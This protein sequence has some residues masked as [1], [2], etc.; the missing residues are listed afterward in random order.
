MPFNISPEDITT[1]YR[2][3]KAD[4]FYDYGNLNLLKFA[5]FE[6]DLVENLHALRNKLLNW[7]FEDYDE[8]VGSFTL[9]MKECVEDIKDKPFV[10]FSDVQR[11]WEHASNIKVDFRIIGQHPVEFHIL[12]SLWID[13][14][15][16]AFLTSNVYKRACAILASCCNYG[17][18][19][20]RS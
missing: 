9:I 8:F 12:S 20:D 17:L 10:F 18:F 13:K 11:N 7:E 1:A 2:K 4:A 5:E 6:Q 15:G 3:A 14:V 16:G 19:Q